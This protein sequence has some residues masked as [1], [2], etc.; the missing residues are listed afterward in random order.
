MNYQEKVSTRAD[1]RALYHKVI[2]N[3]AIK[4]YRGYT[5]SKS[6]GWDAAIDDYVKQEGE[7]WFT[8]PAYDEGYIPEGEGSAANAELLDEQLAQKQAEIEQLEKKQRE[9]ASRLELQRASIAA[10]EV[11]KKKLQTERDEAKRALL[12]LRDALAL[13]VEL[14][15]LK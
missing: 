14:A 13:V 11:E 6:Y 1:V 2:E 12:D 15:S 5:E 9:Q 10:F 3:P 4:C 7:A 8:N